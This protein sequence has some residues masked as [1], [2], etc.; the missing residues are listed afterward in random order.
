MLRKYIIL[1]ILLILS[2]SIRYYT[3]KLFFV[4]K[5]IKTA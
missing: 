2:V 3:G 1:Q 5:N 4:F